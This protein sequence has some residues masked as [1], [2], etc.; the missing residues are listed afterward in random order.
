MQQLS[1]FSTGL[2]CSICNIDPGMAE[3]PSLW[4]GFLDKDTGQYI[5]WSCRNTHY[6]QKSKTQH[7][8]HYSEFPVMNPAVIQHHLKQL[9]K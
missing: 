5:C 3:N 6:Q 7:A 1:M 2:N 9:R 4:N 8:H